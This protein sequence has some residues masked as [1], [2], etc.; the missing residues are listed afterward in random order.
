MQVET[1]SIDYVP[2]SERRG[3]V[4]HQAPFWFTGNFNFFTIAIGFVGPSQGLSF[5]YTCLASIF[6]I[7]FGTIFMALHASQGPDVGL[8]Q[9]VQSRAQF[10]FRGAL[11]PLAATLFTF[12]TFNVVDTLLVSQG[13]A[14]LWGI[15]TVVS[16]I[17]LAVAAILLAIYGYHWLHKVFRVLF[18]ISLP[19][20]AALSVAILLGYI[21]ARGAPAGVGLAWPAFAAQF[22][23]TA[24]YNITFAPYVSDYTRYL[25][26]TGSRG[27]LLASV[28]V[29]A[30]SSAIW[31]IVLG[32]WLAINLGANDGMAAVRDAGDQLYPGLGVA[33]VSVS[34]VALAAAMSLNAY[35]GMLTLATALDTFKRMRPTR[36]LRVTCITILGVVW[37]GVAGTLGGGAVGALYLGLS[38]MLYLLTPWSAI[39]LVD[40]FIVRKRKYAIKQLFAS[41]GMYGR[42]S[43]HGL[44]AYAIGFM[45][46]VPFFVLPGLYIGRVAPLVG[47]AD[48]AWIPELCVS[49]VL[50]YIL[51]RRRDYTNE[52]QTAE[53]ELLAIEAV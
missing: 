41:D 20:Y 13:F 51:M 32:A 29:G 10:G 21:H 30:G 31:L 42:W 26:P 43:P 22:A 4:W 6:G 5:G 28:Y 37:L 19:G 16:S 23:I 48:L 24:S 11:V 53:A 15:N 50:Y 7:L 18:W 45:A 46:G 35:S 8:P 1:R 39:N 34:V 2:L 44:S 36:T 17:S 27:L 9:M 38:A 40:Y 33:L 12:L 47:G 14:T 3:R 52:W 49:G 25:R